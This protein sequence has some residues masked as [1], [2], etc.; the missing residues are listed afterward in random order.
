[1]AID[2]YCSTL[3]SIYSL[4]DCCE[5]NDDPHNRNITVNKGNKLSPLQILAMGIKKY[6]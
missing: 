3:L 4:S 5:S 2:Y 6:K 1:M